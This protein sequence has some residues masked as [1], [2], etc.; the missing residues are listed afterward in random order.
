MDSSQLTC[1]KNHFMEFINRPSLAI[2]Q[3]VCKTMS[4]KGTYIDCN[5]CNQK[6]YD[7][8]ENLGLPYFTCLICEDYDMCLTCANKYSKPLANCPIGISC[9]KKHKLNFYEKPNLEITNKISLKYE[10]KHAYIWCD[11]C[12]RDIYSYENDQG[13]PFYSC[14]ECDYDICL[15]CVKYVGDT[16]SEEKIAKYTMKKVVCLEKHRMKLYEK[17]SLE[18]TQ[19]T[20]A[21]IQDKGIE[22][23]DEIREELNN[24]L[25]VC[26]LCTKDIFD[27]KN[28]KGSV[29]FNCLPCNYNIC[30]D[31]V[32]KFS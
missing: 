25:I 30:V 6:L 1:P 29:F 32:D 3:V 21:E 17:P 8:D 24:K 23:Q 15:E 31:C 10:L 7:Y 2:T 20:I 5:I 22:L 27:Y 16:S 14:S 11:F 28:R 13:K 4:L 18:M 12:L 9:P 26:D 19:K